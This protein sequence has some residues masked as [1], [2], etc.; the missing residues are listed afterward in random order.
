MFKHLLIQYIFIAC[1]YKEE[2][3]G[4]CRIFCEM[5]SIIFF[6]KTK[7]HAGMKGSFTIGPGI[8][9]MTFI[10]LAPSQKMCPFEVASTYFSGWQI[11]ATQKRKC[12]DALGAL[13]FSSLQQ[14][15]KKKYLKLGTF[16]NLSMT[17][18]QRCGLWN[19]IKH[20]KAETSTDDVWFEILAKINNSWPE[21]TMRCSCI[22]F[23]FTNFVFQLAF[24]IRSGKLLELA[25]TFWYTIK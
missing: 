9:V 4:A 21:I 18:L 12:F 2:D 16:N 23:H 3:V 5:I 1:M 19:F 14:F 20:W 10:W 15:K 24:Y 17:T 11:R 22:L 8:N 6:I 13:Q 7:F 25:N